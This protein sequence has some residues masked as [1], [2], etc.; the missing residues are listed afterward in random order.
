MTTGKTIALP[1]RTFVSRVISLLCNTLSR[2]IITSLPRSNCLL[3]SWLQSP[4]AVILEPKKR[5]SVTASTFS[6]AALPILIPGRQ[7]C[8]TLSPILNQSVVPYRVLSVAYLT[9]KVMLKILHT[10]FQ[11]YANQELPDVQ[12]GFRKWRGIRDQIASIL[13]IIE[14][15]R[16]FNIYLCFIHY[17]K[18][19]D[20]G[21][22]QTVETP[23]EMGKP[24]HLTCLLR[25]LYVGQEATEPCMEQLIGSR[26]GKE[27]N[28]AVCC[29][30]FCLIYMLST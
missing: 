20:S 19:F 17:T 26:L 3:I 7:P 6:H 2:F 13:W 29:H 27:Y 4:S 30:P 8:C 25:N 22:W 11:H 5:K 1:M 16:E 14:K 24:D 9:I 18:V 10:R 12:A 21:S 15:A 28:R 23:G